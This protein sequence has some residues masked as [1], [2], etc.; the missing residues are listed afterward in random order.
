MSVSRWLL[1]AIAIGA[2][3]LLG[4]QAGAYVPAFRS[5]VADLGY[6]GP[7]VFIAG[8]AI[9]V[10]GFVPGSALTLAAG[11]I[12]G[13]AEGTLYVFV[14]ATLGASAAF[15]VA[16]YLARGAV[17]RRV[18]R[19]ARFS[20]IDRAVGER[21][22]QIVTL[23]RLSPVFPFTLLNYGLGL[24]RVRFVDYLVAS[25]GMLP[26]TL[27]YVYLGKLGGDAAAAAAGADAGRSPL[28]TTL[29]ILGLVATLVVTVLVTRIARRALREQVRGVES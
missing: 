17:E 11:A 5:W 9:A 7:L 12:F 18:Q 1:L 24:T 14:A 15:L 16:R 13:L 4:F 25:L 22:L 29:L 8:Y 19:D 23:L 10:V 27:L 2:L 21:G 20:A 26:G 3:I 28:E 6:W